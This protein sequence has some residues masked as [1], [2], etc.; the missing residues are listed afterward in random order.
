MLRENYPYYLANRAIFANRDLSV[1]DKY[2][3]QEATRVA[4]A[5]HQR[6]RGCNPRRVEIESQT[7]LR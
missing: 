1:T 2:S 7:G 3:G 6:S 4:L 5:D